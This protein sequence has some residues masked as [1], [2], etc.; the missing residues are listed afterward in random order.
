ML[1]YL[2][3]T[4]GCPAACLPHGMN[5]VMLR[6]ARSHSA[7]LETHAEWGWGKGN[8]WHI[9]APSSRWN[10][11]AK[12]DIAGLQLYKTNNIVEVSAFQFFCL[13]E[14]TAPPKR[15]EIRN[16]KGFKQ[17]KEKNMLRINATYIH[18]EYYT[19][20]AVTNRGRFVRYDKSKWM[21]Y[22]S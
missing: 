17:I 13:T 14:L 11:R 6:R 20:A 19:W 16:K 21:L 7:P 1:R 2:S 15:H 9:G 5:A 10:K 18:S 3:N 8:K 22:R 4:A 12:C